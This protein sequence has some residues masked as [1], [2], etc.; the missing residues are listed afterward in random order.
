[1]QRTALGLGRLEQRERG[2]EIVRAGKCGT[3]LQR[4]GDCQ[5]VPGFRLDQR[6]GQRRTAAHELCE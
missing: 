5:L 4:G 2:S 3:P 6:K 1:M